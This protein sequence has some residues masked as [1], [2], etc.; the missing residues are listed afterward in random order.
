MSRRSSPLKYL[1]FAA[2]TFVVLVAGVLIFF[3]SITAPVTSQD[4]PRLEFVITLGDS[5]LEIA[6]H[7]YQAG[8]IRSPLGFRYLVK[9]NRLGDK[10]QAGTYYLSPNLSTLEIAQSLTRGIAD[11]RLTI[12][13]GYRLEEIALLLEKELSLPSSEFLPLASGLEGSLFPD[14]YFLPASASPS[15]IIKMM[16]D[17]FSLKAGSVDRQA[18]ILASLIE[19]ETKGNPEKPLVAGI[20][21]KRLSAGWPL[22]LDATVQY[23][24]GT[25]K[26]WWPNTTLADRKVNSPYNTYLNP[27]LP[28]GPI[29]NPGLASIQAALHPQSSEY[30]FYLHDSKGTIHYARTLEEHNANI[31]TYLR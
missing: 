24:L 16:Q 23:A 6:D 31:N 7:L 12:P 3:R 2:F 8:L 10:L 14:T 29:C 21:Q 27:G 20:L 18:L 28:P 19:R 26:E 25:K 5:T 13:E 1:L 11:L 9:K 4:S 22:E 30:W 17:N 15:Q